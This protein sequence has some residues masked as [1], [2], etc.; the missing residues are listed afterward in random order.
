MKLNKKPSWKVVTA[1]AAVVTIG[2]AGT[3]FAGD[4]GGERFL[5]SPISLQDRVAV[6][7][8]AEAKTSLVDIFPAPIISADSAD[9]AWDDGSS[10]SD[11]STASPGGLGTSPTLGQGGSD[12]A[13]DSPFYHAPSGNDSFDSPNGS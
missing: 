2:A 7:E 10:T 9:S 13:D 11:L 8:S 3:L 6:T 4:E 1:T 12:S 5:P